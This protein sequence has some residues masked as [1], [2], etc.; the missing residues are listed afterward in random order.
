M[1]LGDIQSEIFVILR[2]AAIL[3]AFWKNSGYD[4]TTKSVCSLSTV[5]AKSLKNVV[6]NN[7]QLT[8]KQLRCQVM[9]KYADF[10]GLGII[11]AIYLI[12][13]Y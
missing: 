10:S 3:D 11:S 12:M 13:Y 9:C 5:N 8:K 1:I 7:R 2:I 6:L 4:T